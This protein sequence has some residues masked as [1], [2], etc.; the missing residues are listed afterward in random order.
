MAD[1]WAKARWLSCSRVGWRRACSPPAWRASAGAELGREIGYQIRFENVTSAA[2]RIRFVTEGV[3]LRQMLH[4][5]TLRGVSAL[6]F[7]EFH[8]RH[9][10]G[11]ITLAQALGL[12]QR[13]RPDLKLLVMSA[14]LDAG[15]LHD[16]LAPCLMLESPGRTFPVE[17]EYATTPAYSEPAPGLGSGRRRVQPI[18]P[19]RRPRRRIGFYAGRLRDRPDSRRLA[20]P[21]RGARF[22][23]VALAR[24]TPAPGTRC[25]RGRL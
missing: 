8:E 4:D 1:R 19:G 5:P 6:I 10:Y 7:D 23:A 25:R 9:L 17:I 24:G 21:R 15:L 14:T 13:E 2:T 16:Y 18:R 11:D 3:L 22:C 20:A 12:Q